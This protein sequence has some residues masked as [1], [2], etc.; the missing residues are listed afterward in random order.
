[1]TRAQHLE[2]YLNDPTLQRSTRR[3]SADD[4]T[5]DTVFQTTQGDTLIV[6]VNMP[7]ASSFASAYPAM[8]LAGV[9]VQHEWVDP[10]TMRVVGYDPIKS[11]A[12]WKESGLSLG[13]V[14]H[15][16]VQQ[17]Q[18]NPPE[19]LEITDSALLSIQPPNSRFR[20]Q[21]QSSRS[22]PRNRVSS[23]NGTEAPP[24]YDATLEN[25]RRQQLPPVP[26]VVLPL[27]PS[28]FDHVLE[29]KSKEELEGLLSD[30]LEFLSLVHQIPVFDNLQV[31]GRKYEA[32]NA[33]LAEGTLNKEQM[34]KSARSEVDNLR[35]T[36]A[37]KVET[38][39]VLERQQNELCVSADVPSV[40]QDLNKAKR[41]AFDESE[42]LAEDWVEEGTL[43]VDAFVKKF[44]EQRK[45][46][47]VRAIKM[48]ILQQK[49]AMPV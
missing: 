17:I 18:L 30:E 39:R 35:S 11:E 33:E 24:T 46:H 15:E 20:Q 2:S 4:T 43:D 22:P 10:R 23:T 21:Q 12:T 14:V 45:V 19:I 13:Q 3:V 47:H 48:D 38:F 28:N 44:M 37:N 49:G 41:A 1:M 6:R 36:L 16:V 40:I 26:E 29:N 32:E 34:L 7:L 31:I 5:Y 27:I 9:R 42:T 25:Q 8:S